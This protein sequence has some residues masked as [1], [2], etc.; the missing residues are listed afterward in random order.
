MSGIAFRAMTEA[1]VVAAGLPLPAREP[2][3]G[4][5]QMAEH[6][7]DE[8]PG[9]PDGLDADLAIHDEIAARDLAELDGDTAEDDD[10]DDEPGAPTEAEMRQWLAEAIALAGD[11]GYELPTGAEVETADIRS[12]ADAGFMTRDEGLW[13]R[14]S[15]GSEWLV[16]IQRR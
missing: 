2:C 8:C 15:D 1:E 5:G 12:M 14:T 16:T 3:P 13:Y 4:C 9:K 10:D 7:P 6:D 11:D